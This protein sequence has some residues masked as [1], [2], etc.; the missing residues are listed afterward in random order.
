[1]NLV[2][3]HRRERAQ[4]ELDVGNEGRIRSKFIVDIHEIF[5]E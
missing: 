5:K 1:M 3:G 2:E 4:A